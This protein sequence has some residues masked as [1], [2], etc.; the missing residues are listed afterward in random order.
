MEMYDRDGD[1]IK[2]VVLE[3]SVTLPDNTRI[4]SRHVLLAE[5]IGQSTLVMS[6]SIG[7]VLRDVVMKELEDQLKR[8]DCECLTK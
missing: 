2:T 1:A 4:S 8:M 6:D 3:C 5:T 7:I